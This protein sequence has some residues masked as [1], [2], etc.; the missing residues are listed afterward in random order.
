MHCMFD[1]P[2][3][4]VVLAVTFAATFFQAFINTLAF[5]LLFLQTSIQKHPLD[6]DCSIGRI[7]ISQP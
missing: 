7:R 1:W 3:P 2:N 6:Y 5:F 4:G